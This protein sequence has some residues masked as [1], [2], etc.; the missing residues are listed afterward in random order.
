MSIAKKKTGGK[1]S[2][3]E[4]LNEQL[5]HKD[6]DIGDSEAFEQPPVEED[7]GGAA[8]SGRSAGKKAARSAGLRRRGA[9]DD[10]F[11]SGKYAAKPVS[12]EEIE[13][14]MDDIFGA[15]DEDDGDEDDLFDD[16]DGAEEEDKS[17]K[18]KKGASSSKKI[19]SQ[20]EFEAQWEAKK[21]TRPTKKLR[22]DGTS[23]RPEGSNVSGV[24]GATPAEDDLLTQIKNLRARQKADMELV[25]GDADAGA[26][27]AA[28]SSSGAASLQ[29]A[30]DILR[31]SVAVYQHLLHLRVKM[32]PLV[33]RAVRF[34]Q[35]DVFAEYSEAVAAAKNDDD[36][37]DDEPASF[38]GAADGLKAVLGDLL[39]GA[40][41]LSKSGKHD[42]AV[43]ALGVN[44]SSAALWKKICDLDKD[45]EKDVHACVEH[46]GARTAGV[47]AKGG[48]FKAIHQPLLDQIRAVIV[49]KARLL[50]KAQRNRS[51]VAIFGHKNA[52]KSAAERAA[53]IA[54][55]DIDEEIFDDA[56]FLKELVHRSGNIRLKDQQSAVESAAAKDL[57]ASGIGSRSGMSQRTKGRAISYQPHPKLVAFMAP[58]PFAEGQQHEALLRSLFQ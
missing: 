26:G 37:D 9:L 39:R 58:V 47:A 55:G 3:S 5:S 53:D 33:Q 50:N 7:F 14:R 57:K 34:P 41:K 17:G 31:A 13:S 44:S 6:R 48:A 4:V 30:A 43:S 27:G 21:K 29:S 8:D 52:E 45:F 11:T 1:K 32:Q 25:E 2:L 42:A 22:A 12:R 18:K 40:A 28:S 23:I 20:E 15:L 49:S 24:K 54:A 56:D 38:E 46:W 51:H 16:A 10:G 35:H 36:E 19:T